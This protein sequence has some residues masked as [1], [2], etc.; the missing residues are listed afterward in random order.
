LR[1]ER[2][3]PDPVAKSTERESLPP[4]VF[5]RTGEREDGAPYVREAIRGGKIVFPPFHGNFQGGNAVL[6]VQRSSS[7]GGSAALPTDILSPLGR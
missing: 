5:R 7:E 4:R 6:P 1:R 3:F 2:G